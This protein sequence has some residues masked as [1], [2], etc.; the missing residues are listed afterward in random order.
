MRLSCLLF[1]VLA[2]PAAAL[3]PVEPDRRIAITIDDLPTHVVEP[4]APARLAMSSPAPADDAPWKPTTL[5]DALR[6]PEKRIIVKALDANAWNRQ[7]TAEQ[8]GINRTTL[9]KKMKAY[10]LLGDGDER[11][12]G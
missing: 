2:L 10:G 7:K 1:L 12:A 9:Y 5:E 3:T 4:E 6:E 11:L 8:L